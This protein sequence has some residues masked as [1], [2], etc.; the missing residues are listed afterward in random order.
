MFNI[1]ACHDRM[2]FDLSDDIVEASIEILRFCNVDELENLEK[3]KSWIKE[4][5]LEKRQVQHI[6]ENV[7]RAWGLTD[8]QVMQFKSEAD[9]LVLHEDVS[10]WTREELITRLVD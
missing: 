6:P 4:N 10:H 8:V 5:N 2:S 1:L 3:A 9:R 7:L